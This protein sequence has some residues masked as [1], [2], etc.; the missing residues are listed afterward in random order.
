[1]VR[2]KTENLLYKLVLG[3]WY[4]SY[5]WAWFVGFVLGI[6]SML[7]TIY[8]L[9]PGMSTMI[10]FRDFLIVGGSILVA[11]N[12][13]VGYVLVK[14]MKV[15]SMEIDIGTQLSPYSSNKLT[16]KEKVWWSAIRLL[17]EKEY[18]RKPDSKLRTKIKEF[19][20]YLEQKRKFDLK[21]FNDKL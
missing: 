9:V 12:A 21:K 16:E 20:E 4:F 11:L 5:G 18:E 17:M 13:I 7:V 1:M 8:Y 3:R 19:D 6:F 14:V 15:Q 2:R 10:A